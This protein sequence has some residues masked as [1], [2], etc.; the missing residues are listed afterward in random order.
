MPKER[1]RHILHGGLNGITFYDLRS[2]LGGKLNG[3]L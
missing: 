1:V 2:A 3:R